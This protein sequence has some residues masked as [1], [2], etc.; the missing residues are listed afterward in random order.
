MV[1]SQQTGLG[2]RRLESG[3]SGRNEQ[4][5]YRTGGISHSCHDPPQTDRHLACRFHHSSNCRWIRSSASPELWVQQR[6]ASTDPERTCHETVPIR[7]DLSPVLP[8]HA[9]TKLWP[10]SA[11]KQ[12]WQLRPQQRQLLWLVNENDKQQSAVGIQC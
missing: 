4:E 8:S 5:P 7:R 10:A 2:S 9:A 12:S 6:L 11:R 1:S 3:R